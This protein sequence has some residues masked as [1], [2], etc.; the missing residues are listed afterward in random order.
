MSNDYPQAG[1]ET[2]SLSVT[3]WVVG[4]MPV[5]TSNETLVS[6]QNL[7]AKTVLGRITASGKLAIHNPG[8]S[9]GSQTAIG[10]LVNDVNAS[11]GDKDC[12]VYT[13]GEFN[14]DLAIFHASVTT[15]LAKRTAFDRT[16]IRLKKTYY[17]N[18]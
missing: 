11:G 14:I 1:S 5:T 10:I 3:Q 2:E 18:I 7:A 8:A 16:P 9:D 13:S 6:G 17:S 4:D 15:D 12:T